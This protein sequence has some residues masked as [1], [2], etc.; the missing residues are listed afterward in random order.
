MSKE[1][2]SI[3][4]KTAKVAGVTCIALGSA[5]LIASGAALKALTAG[6]VYLKDT[7]QKIIGDDAVVEAA[8]AEADFVETEN[9]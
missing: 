7:V 3:V 2:K 1:I 4:K 8:T 5:A 6:A 9:C